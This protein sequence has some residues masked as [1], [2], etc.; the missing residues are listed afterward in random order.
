MRYTDAPTVRLTTTQWYIDRIL[1]S[2]ALCVCTVAILRNTK[3]LGTQAPQWSQTSQ[4]IILKAYNVD[5][6]IFSFARLGNNLSIM[7]PSTLSWTISDAG[8][9]C[10][11]HV[12]IYDRWI[13]RCSEEYQWDI[14]CAVLFLCRS[15]SVVCCCHRMIYVIG[16]MI[17]MPFAILF[18]QYFVRSCCMWWQV[19]TNDMVTN[20]L[21]Y[22]RHF[23][24]V[25]ADT[26]IWKWLIFYW[27]PC[28]HYALHVMAKAVNGSM[29]WGLYTNNNLCI[30]TQTV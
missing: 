7:K 14:F 16:F 29:F 3:T 5:D 18:I 15:Y 20:L 4:M 23:A 22:T 13:I 11:L 27:R 28:C 10:L 21:M 12:S 8:M 17:V 19:S 24:L 9:L 25:F 30:C 6:D 2:P 26:T 1:Q